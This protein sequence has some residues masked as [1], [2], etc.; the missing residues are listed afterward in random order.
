M[1]LEQEIASIKEQIKKLQEE[2]EI[3]LECEQEEG[4]CTNA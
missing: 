4:G 2:L 1:P 3:L